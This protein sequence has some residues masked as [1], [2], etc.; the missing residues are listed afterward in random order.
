MPDP[1][2]LQRK[3]DFLGILAWRRTSLS[4]LHHQEVKISI[5]TVAC[6]LARSHMIALVVEVSFGFSE[7]QRKEINKMPT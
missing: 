3:L 1:T 6:L 4:F 7:E 5:C 2:Q